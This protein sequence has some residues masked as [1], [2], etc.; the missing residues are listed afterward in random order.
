MNKD[1]D[2]TVENWIDHVESLQYICKV[3]LFKNGELIT[4]EG[5]LYPTFAHGE[6]VGAT[7]GSVPFSEALSLGAHWYDTK[8]F[9]YYML[10]CVTGAMM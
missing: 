1:L 5:E 10:E 6:F 7:S 4:R 2:G 3:N 9:L 8:L